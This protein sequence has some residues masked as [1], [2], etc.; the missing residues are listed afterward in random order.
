VTSSK[1][2]IEIRTYH[3]SDLTSLYKICLLTADS[4]NDASLLYKDPDL[5]G[6]LS[7]AP[8]AIFEPELTFIITLNNIP[9]GYILGT[10]NSL[11]FYHKCETDWFPLLRKRYPFPVDDDTSP[12]ASIIRLIHTG[13]DV[14]EELLNYPAHLHVDLLPS[15]QGKGLGRKIMNI[16]IDKLKSLNV[17]ALHLQTGKKNQGAIEFYNKTGFHIIKEYEHTIAFGMKFTE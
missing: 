6:H 5:V 4:G 14:K 1:E 12:D 16:F 7:A 10:K 13:H 3:H 15:I 2:N 17:G 9:T 8:Y 11:N